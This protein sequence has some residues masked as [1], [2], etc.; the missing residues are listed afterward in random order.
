M[1]L[2]LKIITAILL[3]LAAIVALLRFMPQKAGDG[4]TYFQGVDGDPRMRACT[5]PKDAENA[6]SIA[7]S[8][9]KLDIPLATNPNDSANYRVSVFHANNGKAISILL[10]TPK[11][12][13]P[14]I[15]QIG[16]FENGV[17]KFETK[18][19]ILEQATSLINSFE[20][21]K[22]WGPMKTTF[23]PRKNTGPASVVIEINAPNQKR[24]LTTRYDDERVRG[25][26]HEF[27][28]RISSVVKDVDIGGFSPPQEKMFGKAVE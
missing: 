5:L 18:N 26:L 10:R 3:I 15:A 9:L 27:T 4:R 23:E 25:L 28:N 16:V 20:A 17:A 13:I 6:S 7:I 21:A 24:C 1:G 12:D 14:A 19:L 11:K 8:A 22:I 2:R